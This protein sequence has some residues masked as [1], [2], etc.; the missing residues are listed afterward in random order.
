[1][2]RSFATD[3]TG[4][5]VARDLPF[6]IYRLEAGGAGFATFAAS[7]DV[8]TEVPIAY[9]IVLAVAPVR[10]SVTVSPGEGTLL[11]PFRTASASFIGPDLLRDRPS[12][13]PGRSIIDLEPRF[14]SVRNMGPA[15]KRPV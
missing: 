1:M 11:D 4:L 8:R 15:G 14:L 6:G 5:Y 2:R 12:A 3:A 7:I 13:P 9:P 10:A